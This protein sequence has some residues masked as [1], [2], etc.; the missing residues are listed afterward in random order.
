MHVATGDGQPPSK[1]DFI[2]VADTICLNHQSRR[3][4]LESQA[5]DVGPLTSKEAAHRVAGL[6]REESHNL[7]EEARELQARPSPT[8]NRAQ[9]ETLFAA[10]RARADAI[11]RWAAAYD[12]VDER[13]IRLGQIR[14]GLLTARAERVARAYGFSTC[15][16]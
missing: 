9:L 13:G 14:V 6:L 1:T 8:T 2:G 16:R 11:Y 5:S 3:E 10:I 12:E 15:G 4:D 7:S